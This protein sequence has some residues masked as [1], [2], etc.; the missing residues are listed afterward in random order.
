MTQDYYGI[1][2]PDRKDRALFLREY[3]TNAVEELC[4]YKDLIT[5]QLDK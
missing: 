1:T 4:V 3:K 2:R 5:L